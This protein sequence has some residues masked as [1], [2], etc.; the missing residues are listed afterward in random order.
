MQ[1]TDEQTG[2]LLKS[3][4]KLANDPPVSAAQLSIMEKNQ[5]LMQQELTA[6]GKTMDKLVTVVEEV[7]TIRGEVREARKAYESDREVHDTIF[8]HMRELDRTT[9]GCE[10][11]CGGI[12]IRLDKVE[13]SDRGLEIDGATGKT[14]IETVQDEVKGL[15]KVVFWAGT[16]IVGGMLTGF[17]GLLFYVAQLSIKAAV[18]GQ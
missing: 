18:G 1:L 13:T 16:L 8:R 9:H 15:R 5:A 6:I 2:K 14:R 11:R 4:E 10:T 12:Q 3:L 7:N 17:M